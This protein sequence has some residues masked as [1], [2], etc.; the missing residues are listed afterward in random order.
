MQLNDRNFSVPQVDL[1]CKISII[2]GSEPSGYC[3][4]SYIEPF[5]MVSWED[6]NRD[7]YCINLDLEFHKFDIYYGLIQIKTRKRIQKVYN[8]LIDLGYKTNIEG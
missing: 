4:G 6:L 8:L 3:W 5:K 7:E 2:L 1:I